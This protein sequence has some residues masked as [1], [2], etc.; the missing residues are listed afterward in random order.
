MVVELAKESGYTIPE[1]DLFKVANGIIEWLKV[2]G[3]G[4]SGQD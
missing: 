4:R 3:M 1:K 2:R